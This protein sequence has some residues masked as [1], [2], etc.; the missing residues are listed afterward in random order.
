MIL[1][2]RLAY[3]SSSKSAKRDRAPCLRTNNIRAR[4]ISRLGKY[5]FRSNISKGTAFFLQGMFETDLVAKVVTIKTVTIGYLKKAK[6][7]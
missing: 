7:T 1:D 4:L 5:I 6:V 2:E 3:K